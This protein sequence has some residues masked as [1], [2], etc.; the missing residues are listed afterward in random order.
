MK[1][2]V[3]VVVISDVHLGTYGCHARELLYYLNSVQPKVLILNGDIIDIWQFRKRY[4]PKSHMLVIKKI[5]ALAAKGTKVYYLTGNH[6]EKLRKFSDT[7]M[8]NLH[9]MDKLVLKLDDKKAWFFHGDVFDASIKHAKW[10]AK[11]GGWGYDFLILMNRALNWFLNL[12]GRDKYSLSKRIKNSVKSAV[13]FISN[14]EETAAEL[15]IENEYD[16]VVC[17]HIHQPAIRKV[18]NKKG[19]TLYLNSGDWVENLTALEYNNQTWKLFS[20]K[21]RERVMKLDQTEMVDSEVMPEMISAFLGITK[22]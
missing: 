8:G 22:S 3:K 6:D 13:K 17:G 12:I 11:L 19:R 7:R 14:F 2:K 15:A 16:F 5:L 20:Y 1:R 9:I 21:T 10:L 18:K 4:F